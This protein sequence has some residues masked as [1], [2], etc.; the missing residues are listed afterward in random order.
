M[1]RKHM[2][3]LTWITSTEIGRVKRRDLGTQPKIT[4]NSK[5]G[6][7]RRNQEMIPWWIFKLYEKKNQ[8]N[9]CSIRPV[10]KV[11]QRSESD[12]SCPMLLSQERSWWK[13]KYSFGHVLLICHLDQGH[14]GRV[15][16]AKNTKICGNFYIERHFMIP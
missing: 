1:Y 12:Q 14:C 16:G 6:R 13:I 9:V 4:F 10:K 5:S 11:I 3:S 15:F 2:K 8:N 7:K